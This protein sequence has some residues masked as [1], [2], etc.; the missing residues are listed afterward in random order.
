V[1]AIGADR[2]KKI[3]R[4]DAA[5]DQLLVGHFLEAHDARQFRSFWTWMPPTIRFT[6]IRKDGSSTATTT[7]T[8][9]CP[10]TSSVVSFC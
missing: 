4:D 1:E 10:C 7:P 3:G 2:Y 8:V 5:I 6:D 9:I